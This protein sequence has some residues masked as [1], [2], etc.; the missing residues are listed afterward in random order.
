M[1]SKPIAFE[2]NKTSIFLRNQELHLHFSKLDSIKKRKNTYLPN[3]NQSRPHFNIKKNYSTPSILRDKQFFILR[4]NKLIYKKLDK[5]NHR[6]NLLNNESEIIDGYLSVKK[7]TRDK[8]RELKKD[9]I[10]KEN[11]KLKER[12]SNTKP[13]IDKKVLD[14]QFQKLKKISGF[15][16]K[17]RPQDK[18]GNIFINRKE[19]QILRKYGKENIEYFLKEKENKE[20]KES[21]NKEQEHPSKRRNIKTTIDNNNKLNIHSFNK[22]PNLPFNIDKKILKK[23]AYI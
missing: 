21:N 19:S 4:D 11:E 20:N 23:I 22:K 17:V 5:I 7:Y 3:I 13:V 6:Q 12:I 1:L 14:D 8:F 16:R 15:M 2:Q 18:L 10:E 9:L